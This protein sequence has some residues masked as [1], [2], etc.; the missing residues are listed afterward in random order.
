MT[1]SCEILLL[2]S[3]QFTGN[4]HFCLGL[5]SGKLTLFVKLALHSVSKG[6]VCQITQNVASFDNPP[7]VWVA[8]KK[9]YKRQSKVV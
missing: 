5:K 1:S 4:V 8:G 2:R 7:Q 3:I 6:W 9:R